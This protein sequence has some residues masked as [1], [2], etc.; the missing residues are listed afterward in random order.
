ME[1]LHWHTKTAEQVFTQLETQPDTG[2]S[3]TE[4]QKRQ[5]KFGLNLIP[6]PK[7][8]S[9][10]AIFVGQFL[11]PL[12]YVLLAAGVVS[13][14]A[15]ELKDAAFIFAIIVI[16]AVLGT[17]QEWRAENSASALKKLVKV[18]AR[19]KREG[20]LYTIA[21]EKLVPGDCVLL[22]SGMKVP[23]FLFLSWLFSC[24]G[25]IW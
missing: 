8:K 23:A 20:K 5:N 6:E 18:N 1:E 9:L 13:F 25:S 24:C 22:E 16:N 4:V 2:L 11:S 21:S 14:F 3:E 12:I 10:L 17:Y 7:G 19:V 15:I